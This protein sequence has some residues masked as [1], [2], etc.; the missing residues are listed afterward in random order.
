MPAALD[1]ATNFASKSL[2]PALVTNGTFITSEWAEYFKH[3]GIRIALSVYSYEAKE[4]D[5]V[6]NE[7]GSWA[8]TNNAIKMLAAA[9]VKYCVRNVLLKGIDVGEKNTKLYT[10]NKERDVVRMI[11]MANA[12]LLSAEN[13]RKRL[14]T[15]KRF[16]ARIKKANVIRCV[17][18]NNC[19]STHI[20]FGFDGTIYPCV[21]ERRMS[22]GNIFDAPLAKLLKREILDFGKDNIVECRNCEFRYFC[23]DCRPDSMGA[24]VFDKPWYCT[25]RPLIGKWEDPEACVKK[26]LLKVKAAHGSDCRC[27]E[28]FKC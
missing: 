6:T 3:N 27:V 14:I 22:H 11:K 10:L 26:I 17:S 13:I 25:Y 1:S 12:Q 28:N 8:K 19:F 5:A 21:M 7:Q 24:G 15:K 4:H 2:S 16:S 9:G 18:G 20:Y 23:F